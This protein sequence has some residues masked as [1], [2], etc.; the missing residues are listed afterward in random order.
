MYT[1]IPNNESIPRVVIRW[2]GLLSHINCWHRIRTDRFPSKTVLI[3]SFTAER[4]SQ[5][6]KEAEKSFTFALAHCHYLTIPIS[7]TT[8]RLIW[9]LL[10]I[11]SFLWNLII[12][13][14]MAAHT[15]H[16]NFLPFLAKVVLFSEKCKFE[17]SS[18]KCLNISWKIKLEFLLLSSVRL[19][20]SQEVLNFIYWWISE[21]VNFNTQNYK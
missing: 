9:A 3:W 13:Q 5:S 21:F 17:P 14:M 12:D 15:L 2:A 11:T 16:H 8:S 18:S 1:R 4:Y 7:F 19:N 20:G 6:W 10:K